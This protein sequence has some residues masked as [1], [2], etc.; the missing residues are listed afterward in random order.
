MNSPSTPARLGI[1]G[2]LYAFGL[3]FALGNIGLAS[4]LIALQAR[5]G[6]AVDPV[7]V[8]AATAAIV[9][10]GA[11]LAFWMAHRIAQP[12]GALH[13]ALRGLAD[14][15]EFSG[16]L[17]LS[18][19]DEIGAMARAFDVLRENA[20]ARAAFED[21]ARA[22]A[23]QRSEKQGRADKLIAEFRSSVGTVLTAVDTS[24]RKLDTTASS[25]TNVA[26]EASTQAAAATS[27]SEQ[28]AANVQ[29]VASA[30]EELGS[31]VAEIGRQVMQANT[32]VTDATAMANRTNEQVAALAAAAQK[33]GDVVDL[34][35]A[36][37]EQTNLLALN[38]TI[39][40]ARAGEAGKGFAV[41]A[42]EVKSLANQTAKATEE[43]GG[44]VAGIQS[45]TKDAVDAIGKIAATMG[46]INRFTSV[47]AATVEEQTAATR[48]I[49]RNVTLASEGT[50]TVA[51]NVA[52]VTMAIGE[53][54]RSAKDVQTAS[55]ELAQA[56][57][58][59]QSSVDRFVGEVAA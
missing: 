55:G 11:A 1:R 56:A 59:L 43:I 20:A 13:D 37:A 45:S 41:V 7:Q 21:K 57:R 29:S 22:D 16:T 51:D 35:K 30:T 54:S 39:E 47:I 36:I 58:K 10:I 44:Q 28:A 14:R 52:T 19:S 49:S 46:E 34:I 48:E 24:M 42:S 4:L 12:L 18:R 33:I 5:R 53:A 32:V 15:G 27:A 2:R 40:A 38:A 31:S 23:A 25:L 26:G 6:Q 50:T 8:A 3:L 17:D 9:V